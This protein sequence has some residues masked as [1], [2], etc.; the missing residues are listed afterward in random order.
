MFTEFK[1]VE[2]K[3]IIKNNIPTKT[4]KTSYA[5]KYKKAFQGKKAVS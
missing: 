4:K 2:P 5:T 3:K 1:T